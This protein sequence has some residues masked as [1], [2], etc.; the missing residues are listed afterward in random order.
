MGKN[1]DGRTVQF[2]AV[3][4]PLRQGEEGVGLVGGDG[5]TGKG[6]DRAAVE[7]F[8]FDAALVA[9]GELPIVEREMQSGRKAE[10]LQNLRQGECEAEFPPSE[11]SG[12][13]FQMFFING[14]CRLP[15]YWRSPRAEA[16]AKV[17]RSIPPPISPAVLFE[18]A[19]FKAAS[20]C[21]SRTAISSKTSPESRKF[22]GMLGPAI[23]GGR[24]C[25]FLCFLHAHGKRGHGTKQF[26]LQ[27]FAQ[28]RRSHEGQ[29]QQPRLGGIKILPS[30]VQPVE[31]RL[32]VRSGRNR[33]CLGRLLE[34]HRE[35]PCGMRFR[36][37]CSYNAVSAS[38]VRPSSGQ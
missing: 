29:I 19:S 26:L 28:S 27:R 24:C 23:F 9:G 6:F 14:R 13:V 8:P 33:R 1:L 11:Y 4:Q 21:G 22:F 31:R 32:Q 34:R 20:D 5:D 3:A 15:D 30:V 18:R 25:S 38:A 17:A 36:P 16:A 10:F 7:S 2:H 12:A 35:A 37:N